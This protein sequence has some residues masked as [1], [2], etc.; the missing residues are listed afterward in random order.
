MREQTS[1]QNKDADSFL[2]WLSR[3]GSRPDAIGG[4]ARDL[5]EQGAITSTDEHLDFETLHELLLCADAH[6]EALAVFQSAW[7]E[8][9]QNTVS[10]FVYF[11]RSGDSGPIK[12]GV[13]IDPEKRKSEL[14]TSHAHDLHTLLVIPG[15]R[16][17]ETFLH[18]RFA[19][20]RLRG[21]WFTPDASLLEFIEAEKAKQNN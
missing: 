14:Q 9:A 5:I 1:V 17:T 15:T 18:R 13:S 4:F 6:E 7:K 19:E 20:F 21:E 2:S 3:Q 12:I 16:D 8:Y 11:I 10:S